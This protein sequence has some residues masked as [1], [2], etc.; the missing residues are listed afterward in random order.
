MARTFP[1]LLALCLTAA[2]GDA[3]P[4]VPAGPL[5][6]D[7]GGLP[8]SAPSGNAAPELTRI[9]DR[10][11][12][13]GRALVITVTATDADGDP[14][15]YAL[16]GALPEGARFDK[17]TQ[18]FEWTPAE[19]GRTAHLT[20]VV[21]DGTET[22]RETVRVTTVDAATVNPPAFAPVGDRTIAAEAPF[23]LALV[24]TDPDGDAVTFSSDGPLPEGAT[25][26]GATGRFGWT[27]GGAQAGRRVDLT[28]TASDGL[29][30]TSQ[31]VRLVV[32]SGDPDLPRPPAFTMSKAARANLDVALS[33]PVTAADPNGDALAFG[34]ARPAPAGASLEGG[35]LRWTPRE[36]DAG[37]AVPFVLSASDG[38][39]TAVHVV[40]VTV[41]RPAAGA[42]EAD[43]NEPNDQPADATPLAG[44][45]TGF[46]CDTPEEY[47]IDYWQL[48]ADADDV[49]GLSLS[50][51]GATADLDLYLLAPDGDQIA[52]S[53]TSGGTEE[54]RVTAPISGTYGVV[55]IGYSETPL[56]AAYRLSAD[57][58]GS[59][60]REDPWAGNH[61]PADA[62]PLGPEA[63]E[64]QLQL[65]AGAPDYWTFEAT[66]GARIEA[67]LAIDGP[68][69]EETDLDLYVYDSV[70]G[71]GP[72]GAEP[73]GASLGE[74]SLELVEIPAATRTGT[75]L[76]EVASH[77]N[78]TRS[79][80]YELVVTTDGGCREDRLDNGS[81]S[82]ARLLDGA[83]ISGTLCCADD[84][85]RL[86]L[87]PGES[88]L[89]GLR[90]TSGTAGLTGLRP[91]GVTVVD[92][93][94]PAAT[95]RVAVFENAMGG[96]YYVRVAG[97]PGA[98]YSL[99]VTRE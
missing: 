95:E 43:P 18:R 76:V 93:D 86:T 54:L 67:L 7:A 4:D 10:V 84:W 74:A 58:G 96:T 5:G 61:R 34:F 42:C 2:C 51:D 70:D 21:T 92:A 49:I 59:T 94:P 89:V 9:G 64:A 75:H 65:C 35:V 55:V 47:D 57:V 15:S 73:V 72:S 36:A 6:P 37:Q 32:D 68:G 79:A 53:L 48:E 91:D 11:A 71:S 27:P 12:P 69:T 52:Q 1:A 28:F 45:A 24:A 30:V 99:S 40:T 90:P 3:A 8:D 26:D 31:P 14:L 22:D 83:P 97:S 25:L 13:V 20:F 81:L 63:S 85:F 38:T 56:A 62:A 98:T 41:D 17:A 16:Y 44:D 60:C 29:S 87:Q 77:P 82:R 19:A 23:E 50:F 80:A 88:A 39:F 66:C 78:N 46:I 33:L